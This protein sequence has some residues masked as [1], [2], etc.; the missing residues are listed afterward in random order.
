MRFLVWTGVE[1][2]LTEAAEVE[3]GEDG[4]RAGG[5]QLGAEPAPFR[6]DYRLEAPGHYVTSE[7]ELTATAE[8]WSRHLLLRHDGS[9]GWRADVSDDGE[10]PDGPWDGEL[11]DLSEARDIDIENSPL[12]N[13]MPILREGFQASGSGDFVMAFVRMP[14]LRVEASPQRYEHVRTTAN[15]SVVRYISRDGDFTAD[16]E[17]DREGLL[18]FYPRLARR[19]EPSLKVG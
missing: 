9:G 1:E 19:V 7:L 10:V 11:P 2:W 5:I 12:T 15:G 14:T 18:E 4:L 3:L 16:L 6:V 8:G 17:L 13:T